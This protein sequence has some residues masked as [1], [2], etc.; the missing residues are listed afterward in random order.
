MPADIRRILHDSRNAAAALHFPPFV[1]P[2]RD[3]TP[4]NATPYVAHLDDL[5][6]GTFLSNRAPFVAEL[7]AALERLGDLGMAPV[8]ALLGGSAIGPKPDPGDLDCIIFYE[9]APGQQV[10]AEGGAAFRSKAKAR[11]LD[12]R[13]VPIDGDPV[14]LL[15]TVSYFSMLF[16]KKEGSLRIERGL[17]LIDCRMEQKDAG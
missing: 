16:S 5:R 15:K 9:Q 11:G 17:V 1:G 8:A 13:L 4:L 7:I 2:E 10:R 14:L 3:S 6:E 12:C